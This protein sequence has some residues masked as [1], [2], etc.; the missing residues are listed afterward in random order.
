M[1]NNKATLVTHL[2]VSCVFHS[3]LSPSL[4][5]LVIHSVSETAW[6]MQA[7]AVQKPSVG[8]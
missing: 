4:T 2:C 6:L 7:A 8:V 3:E 5:T 1:Q